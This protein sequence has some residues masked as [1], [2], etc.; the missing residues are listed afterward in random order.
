MKR[1]ASEI[2]LMVAVVLA[3]S[4][5]LVMGPLAVSQAAPTFT[6]YA[7]DRPGWAA[8]VVSYD[9][10]FFEDATLNLGVTV[11]TGPGYV[12]VAKGVWW[13]RLTCPSSGLTTTTWQFDPPIRGFGAY[14]NPGV[15][16]GPGAGIKVNVGGSWVTVGEIPNNYTG[17]FWGFVSTEPFTE[18]RLEPGS[19]CNG[20]W[21][22]TYEMDNMVYSPNRPPDCSKA[23]PSQGTIW[24]PNHK[25]VPITVLG[26]TDPD[27]DPVTIKI[28]KIY[29]DELLNTTG[30]GNFVPDG[31]GLGTSTAEVRAERVGT[32]AVP[33]DGRF[34]HI[35]F[36]AEDGRGGS[37]KGEVL[38]AVPHDQ[39]KKPV[40]GG[41]KYDSTLP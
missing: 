18:V 2:R 6:V 4:L 11:V 24:P 16:G 41:A 37:C 13:D 36:K 23:A 40:D 39:N 28:A 3:L 9:E 17:Q 31:Q 22:E 26:V 30:D 34:Y 15:P 27:G 14:W 5:A 10:E 38:V 35:F 25:F 1:K 8:A 7:N 20:A 33:G 21:A 12:D 32:P 19:Y 29:Q